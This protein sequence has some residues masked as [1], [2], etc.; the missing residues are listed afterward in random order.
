MVDAAA[1]SGADVIKFQ[2]FKTEKLVTADA[3]KAAYQQTNTGETGSQFSMLKKLELAE[4]AHVLLMNYCRE[5]GITFMSTPFDA[6]SAEMLNS[7]NV[8]MFKVGSGDLTNLPLLRQLAG[9]GRPIIL[10]TGMADM[11]EIGKALEVVIKGGLPKEKI[12]V[13]HANTDYPTPYSDVNLTA[14][15]AIK[16]KFGVAVGYSDH[17][18]G[19]EVPV[20]AVAL[21]AQVIEKH[22]TLDRNLEGPDHKA[23]LEP[24][25]LSAMVRSIRNI[26][27]ALGHG[28]KIPSAGERK[29]MAA[30]RKSIVAACTIYKGEL[31]TEENLTVKRPGTGICPLRWDQIIG[32]FATRDYRKDELI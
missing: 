10:S 32:T 25:E 5:K 24:S 31:F 20:A 9:Y 14:M 22:F 7:L 21:G 26:E 15:Q 12:I 18:D 11:D 3:P 13:L 19:I 30:A 17:T 23:S 8:E 6:E 1:L 2:S 28:K 16:R 27:M 29:N 4:D